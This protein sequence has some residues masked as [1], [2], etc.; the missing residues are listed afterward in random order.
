MP[1]FAHIHRVEVR[2]SDCDPLGHV[3]H[4]MFLSYFEHCHLSY[5]R[6]ETGGINP[7]VPLIVAHVE[8]DYRAPAFFGDQ[9]DVRMNISD[10]GRSSFSLIFDAVN[11]TSGA[12]LADGKA[13]LVAY[14][15]ATGTPIPLREETR[16]LLEKTQE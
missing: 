13:V 4:V 9:I 3:N 7:K 1:D 14:D 16:R 2:F 6:Q 8:C 15:Y 5:W 11:V 12:K 10:I